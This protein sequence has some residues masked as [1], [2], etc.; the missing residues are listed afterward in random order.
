M[1]SARPAQGPGL[2]RSA[3]RRPRRAVDRSTGVPRGRRM[4]GFTLLELT[5]VLFILGLLIAGLF[6]PL[7]T[8]LEAR[9]RRQ[10]QQALQEITDALYG[11]ALTNR[12]LPCPDTDGDGRSDPVFDASDATTAVCDQQVGILPWSELAVAQSDAWGNR[13]TYAVTSRTFTLPDT[14]GLCN[15]G[16]AAGPHYDLC[17]VGNL[18]VRSRGDDPASAGAQESKHELTTYATGLPA[19]IVSHGRNGAGAQTTG[20]ITLPAPTGAD[21]LENVDDDATFMSRGY[22]RGTAGCAD[23]EDEGT[24]LCEF[25]D[26]VV[27]LAPSILNARMVSA[28]R[29]P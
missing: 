29:L 21:E 26:L 17:S 24:A 25:D 6:G 16:D 15:A 2:I 23:D 19:V 10:T 8:Q 20:G 7:E 14:D 18:T 13:F 9:D 22:A 27:W 4:R 3:A 11:F 12:R 1:N 5:V 28:G